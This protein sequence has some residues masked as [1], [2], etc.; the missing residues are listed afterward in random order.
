MFAASFFGLLTAKLLRREGKAETMNVYTIC[1]RSLPVAVISWPIGGKEDLPR[2]VALEKIA[3]ALDTWL[4]V[5]VR[6]LH[7]PGSHIW[8][9]G[10]RGELSVREA[11]ADE[12]AHWQ[13]HQKGNNYDWIQ[14][15]EAANR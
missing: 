5:Q 6:A 3:K 15:L 1:V 10:D 13:A 4:G 12:T 9:G 11:S 14:R 8:E 7:H 2:D